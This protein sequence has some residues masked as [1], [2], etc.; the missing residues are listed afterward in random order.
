MAVGV[1]REP[2]TVAELLRDVV[3]RSPFVKEQRGEAV[4]QVIR[5]SLLDVDRGEQAAGRVRSGD[6]DA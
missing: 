1:Q 4:A 3:H 6:D 2:R 5:A